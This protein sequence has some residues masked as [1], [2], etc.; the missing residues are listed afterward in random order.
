MPSS[1][2]TRSPNLHKYVLF[3]Q[4]TMASKILS[5]LNNHPRAKLAVQLSLSALIPAAPILYWSHDAKQERA[6]RHRE[7]STRIR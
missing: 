4:L 2:W 5:Q 6:E 7:V 1:V 3:S